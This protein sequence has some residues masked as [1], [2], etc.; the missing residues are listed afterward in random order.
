MVSEPGGTGRGIADKDQRCRDTQRRGLP[1]YPTD[2]PQGGESQTGDG[3]HE[4]VLAGRGQ[5]RGPGEL[6]TAGSHGQG[7]SRP[8]E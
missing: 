4:N 7:S 6:G 3:G 5:R 2:M 1:W 8:G